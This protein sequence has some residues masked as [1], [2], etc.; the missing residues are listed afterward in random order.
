M[1]LRHC[2]PAVLVTE[3]S[4]W[5]KLDLSDF[6]NLRVLVTEAPEGESLSGPAGIAVERWE[7]TAQRAFA[8]VARRRSDIASIV[9]S[10]GTGGTPKG[11]QLTHGN[12]L[13][14]AEVLASMYPMG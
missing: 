4:T 13:A 8:S 9:Y 3:Y 7:Q 2:R 6:N 1:L 10:S 14:Q 5:R 12:Y 11:C